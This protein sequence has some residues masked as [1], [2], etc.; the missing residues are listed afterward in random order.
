MAIAYVL[1]FAFA[2]PLA[3]VFG[4]EPE[5]IALYVMVIRCCC[6]YF[7]TVPFTVPTLDIYQTLGKV[8]LVSLLYV[9]N[10]LVFPVITFFAGRF[11]GLWLIVSFSW[12]S[13]LGIIAVYIIYYY[14]RRKKLPGSIF[15]ITDI[16]DKIAVPSKDRCSA[17]IT[18]I[19][20][21]IDASEK[22][23][24]FCNSKG[25]SLKTS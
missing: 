11:V 10:I 12:I 25:M 17:T 7:I 14:A 8:R 24:S 4:A 9:L 18:K 21:A 16:P 2:H 1:I 3:L 20:E 23:V 13:D 19:S 15:R 5:E 6:F 22:M